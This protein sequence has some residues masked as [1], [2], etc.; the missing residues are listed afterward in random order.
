MH[1]SHVRQQMQ[2]GCGLLIAFAQAA[3]DTVRAS[4]SSLLP[5]VIPAVRQQLTAEAP[6]DMPH[7]SQPGAFAA[8]VALAATLP[9]RISPAVIASALQA[10]ASAQAARASASAPDPMRLAVHPAMETA[11][12]ALSQHVQESGPLAGA[13]YPLIFPAVAAILEL[14]SPSHLHPVALSI[15]AAHV[16]VPGAVHAN[17]LAQHLVKICHVAE[18]AQMYRR[19][20]QAMLTRLLPRLTSA[21]DVTSATSGFVLPTPECRRI[22]LE[23]ASDSGLYS[24]V[25]GPILPEDVTAALCSDAALA[26]LW[27]A[28]HDAEKANADTAAALWAHCGDHGTGSVQFI[29]CVLPYLE[30][31]AP[32]IR[33]AAA[34][35]ASDAAGIDSSLVTH[36]VETATRQYA[37]GS[38]AKRRGVAAVVAEIAPVLAGPSQISSVMRFV[39][40]QGLTDRDEGARRGFVEAGSAL[41]CAHGASQLQMLMPLIEQYLENRGGLAEDLY[42]QVCSP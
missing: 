18:V 12:S 11:L 27:V 3:P 6:V 21:A 9:L 19:E 7:A 37:T 2:V 32:S 5:L 22:V 1:V 8:V 34:K 40:D 42:D 10:A 23:A 39:L 16:E 38:V 29:D 24:S 33:A 17:L 36:L 35:A 28:M 4:I 20:A 25:H 13:E 41:V 31:S 15:V 30:N 26:P 14:P